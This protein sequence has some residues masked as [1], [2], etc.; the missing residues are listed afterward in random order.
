L[1]AGGSSLREMQRLLAVLAAGR[2]CAETGTA[3]GEG[4]A[5][6]ASTAKSL[7]TVESDAERAAVAVER[8]RSF[9]NVELLVGDWREHLPARGPYELIFFDAGRAESPRRRCRPPATRRSRGAAGGPRAAC[10]G[11]A[12]SAGF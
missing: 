3:F 10:G 7:V 8:L 12:P 2:H 11:S 1:T 6:I 4:A 5:A 9:D